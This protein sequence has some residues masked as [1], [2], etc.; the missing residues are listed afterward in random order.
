MLNGTKMWISNAKWADLFLVMAKID[1]ERFS[2]FLVERNFPG[3]T[4]VAR[5]E[6]KMGLKGSSTARL[7]LE[8]AVIPAEKSA[9]PGRVGTPRRV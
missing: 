8:D 2:A 4:V 5:E 7:V 9:S 1:G 6:H 3:V